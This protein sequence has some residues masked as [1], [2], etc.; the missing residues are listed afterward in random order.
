MEDISFPKPLLHLFVCI[1]DRA[2]IPDSKPSCGPRITADEVK[3]I[4]RWIVE[5]GWAGL[6]YC[7]KVKCL[8]FCNSEASVAVLYPQGRFVKYNNRQELQQM[9]EEEIKQLMF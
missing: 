2:G 7:T 1:N 3:E 8:G 9:I 4:K 5:R 6:V